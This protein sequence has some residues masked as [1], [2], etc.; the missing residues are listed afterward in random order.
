MMLFSRI[1]LLGLIFGLV[2]LSA[3]DTAEERA[4]GH[5]QRGMQLLEAGEP[6]KALLEFRNA[7][8]LDEDA[9][10]PRLEFARIRLAQGEVW[11][12]IG[13]FRR[14]IEVDE[15]HLEAR[16]SVSRLLLQYA[17]ETDGAREHVTAA[18]A[19]APDNVEVRGLVAGLAQKEGR[20]EEAKALATALL[21]DVPGNGMAVSVLVAQKVA[22]EDYTGVITLID[23]ALQTSPDDLGMHVAKLQALEALKDQTAIGTQLEEM[24]RRFPDNPQV[25]Q[26]RVQWFLNNGDTTAAIEAQRNLASLFSDEPSYALQVAVLLNRFEGAEVARSELTELANS[27]AH[28]VEIGRA[29][30]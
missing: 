26:G 18:A 8:Q 11:G 23:D 13:N 4:E 9:I 21:E 24:S 3:C 5:Y 7:L 16:I 30:V 20:L 28:K 29:H 12:A 15:N 10:E 22:D 27:G 14:V 17:N 1:R 25:A 2:V 6:E 19:L